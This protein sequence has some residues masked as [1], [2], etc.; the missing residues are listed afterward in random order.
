MP[1]Q[2][3][4]FSSNY[5]R[6]WHTLARELPEFRRFLRMPPTA[7][8]DNAFGHDPAVADQM[9]AD[10]VDIV[11]LALRDRDQGGVSSAAR[12]EAAKFRAP[13]RHRGI[14]GRCRDR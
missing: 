13:Q 9:F 8:D 5:T 4:T 1:F 14:D 6:L 12:L 10:D 3:I 11:E 2:A 7:A